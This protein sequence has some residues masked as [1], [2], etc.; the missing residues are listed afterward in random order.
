MVRRLLAVLAG[1]YGAR[2]ARHIV[3]SAPGAREALGRTNFR[4]R[5]VSL[6]GGLAF[7]A[8]A[9][10]AGAAAASAAA[11]RAGG[12]AGGPLVGAAALVAGLGSAAVGAYDDAVT[13][14]P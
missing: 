10:L 12:R 5:E 4:G 11:T 1:A 2:T 6:S 3:E 9:S 8:G 14:R 13:A 7:A